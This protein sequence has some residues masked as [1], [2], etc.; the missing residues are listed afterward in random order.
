M[1]DKYIEDLMNRNWKVMQDRLAYE[2]PGERRKNRTFWWLFA[3]MFLMLFCIGIYYVTPLSESTQ[4]PEPQN[5]SHVPTSA[6]VIGQ[7]PERTLPDLPSSSIINAQSQTQHS[8][9]KMIPVSDQYV[10]N[11]IQHKSSQKYEGPSL[12]DTENSFISQ[13]KK[14]TT[15]I[16]DNKHTDL[17]LFRN[18]DVTTS[19]SNQSTIHSIIEDTPSQEDIN[20]SEDI[21]PKQISAVSVLPERKFE[22]ANKMTPILPALS[23]AGKNYSWTYGIY[24]SAF[25]IKTNKPVAYSGGIWTSKLLS[26]KLFIQGLI[27]YQSYNSYLRVHQINQPLVNSSH[28]NAPVSSTGS[29][30]DVS[31][32]ALKSLN[33]SE[34]NTINESILSSSLSKLNYLKLQCLLG[35]NI[36][37]NT[38]ILSGAG[39]QYRIS[40][41]YT[42]NTQTSNIYAHI[43]NS[44][45][46]A[47]VLERG[48]S[49]LRTWIPVVSLGL[50]YRI[51]KGLSARLLT[52]LSDIQNSYNYLSQFELANPTATS[53]VNLTKVVLGNKPNNGNV[54]VEVGLRWTIKK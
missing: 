49:L 25:F 28:L 17:E 54:T 41:K 30:F 29:L 9:E 20:Q 32:T 48:N 33:R 8:N 21:L 40:E 23:V 46:N 51:N 38:T 50:E 37:K 31:S 6:S 10:P 3:G 18:N 35:Y 22:I 16:A 1:D 5:S 47:D 14:D 43:V 2:M 13:N 52:N 11:F 53:P 15:L 45:L 26:E 4:V 7:V 27:T 12:P 44:P 39:I 36:F 24:G 42:L 19:S 34:V